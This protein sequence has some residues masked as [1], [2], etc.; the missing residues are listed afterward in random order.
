MPRRC[1]STARSRSTT[2][3]PGTPPGP[4]TSPAPPGRPQEH[5]GEPSRAPEI[6][7]LAGAVEPAGLGQAHHQLRRGQHLGQA[8]AAR[9]GHGRRRH[10]A[11][12]QGLRRRPRHADRR[13]AWRC[14][15][16]TACAPSRRCTPAACTRTTSST[17]TPGLRLRRRRRGAVDR[18]AAARVRRRRP[19]RPPPPRRGDRPR[20]PRPTASGSSTE[21]YGGAVGWLDWQ[22]PGLRA[23][24]ALRDLRRSPT[25]MPSAPCSAATG[26]SP[27]PTPA[28]PARPGP[29]ELVERAE[30]FLARRAD[31]LRPSA[32]LGPTPVRLDG[33]EPTRRVAGA[34]AGAARPG[35]HRPARR[36]SLRRPTRSCSTCS[37][38]RRRPAAGGAR[39]LVPRPLPAHQGPAAAARPPPRRLARR[40]GRAARRR[41]HAEYRAAYAAYY[42]RLRRQPTSP[43]RRGADPVIVLVPGVGMWSFG[44]D[45]GHR[46]HR[47]RVL[48][49]RHQRHARR[50]VGVGVRADRPTPRS[51]ASSTGSSRS[52]SCAPAA[53]HRRC[54]GRVA[55][56][57]G[58]ASGIGRA[59][60]QRLAAEGAVRRG[61]RPRPSSGREGRRRDRRPRRAS[62]LAADVTD[63][64]R[65]RMRPSPPPCRA[66]R[67][68]RPRREQRRVRHARP[69]S[70]TRPSRT[71]TASTRCSLAA[72]SS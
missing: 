64:A 58:G 36:R 17:A 18:H 37:S 26:S 12:R 59:I 7:A 56:V 41:P 35:V 63:E 71:G 8:G 23:R 51:S 43:P 34:G 46:P 5:P 48:P 15:G 14:C 30:A 38:T 45:V 1:T 3:A 40:P 24:P 55:L 72:R 22:R 39:H 6:E 53:A 54:S 13:T 66:L 61:R 42:D 60:A 47:R 28:T 19:R 62:A 9:P 20:R 29:V 4:T 25:P 11:R 68:R 65:G 69:R 27:G 2:T 57:T 33:D 49:Q 70:S 44:A 16:S 67:R 21:C 50:R 31:R 32:V 10:G 52:A